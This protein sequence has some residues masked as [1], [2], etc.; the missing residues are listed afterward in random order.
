MADDPATTM[1]ALGSERLDGAL[2]AVKN[3]GVTLNGDF[4]GFIV[5]VAA[6][7]TLHNVCNIVSASAG[8]LL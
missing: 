2:K 5:F 6:D 1:G 8:G 7:F 4:Q 3:V